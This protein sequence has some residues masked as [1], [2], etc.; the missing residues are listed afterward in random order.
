M[1]IV[2]SID[3]LINRR[4]KIVA[5]VGPA[6]SSPQM[7]EALIEAGV[8]VFRLNMSHG[9][10]AG[11]QA[12]Y[13]HIRSIAERLEKPVA[14]LAD[15]CGPKIRTGKFEDDGIDLLEGDEVKITMGQGLGKAGVIVSQY[16]ALARDVKVNDRILLAD[17]LFELCVLDS[18]E[19]EVKCR[20]VQGGRLTNNKGMNLPGVDVSSPC[21]TPKDIRDAEFAKKLG[22]DFIA[23]SF[24]RTAEDVLRLREL[25]VDSG[26]PPAIVAKIEK[27]EALD[28]AEAIL[29]VTDAIMIARGDLGVELPPEE[30]PIA[31]KQLI[32]MAI[33]RG[34]PVIV[35]TQ[36]LESMITHAR[37]TRAEVTDVSY[38]VTSGADAV[39]L[40]AETAAGDFPIDSVRM[41]DRVARQAE[42]H[43]WSG[44]AWGVELDSSVPV[45]IWTA[46]A[47]AAPKMSKN[48]GA[49][50][51]IV[52]SKSGITVQ[53]VSTARPAAPIL[54]VTGSQRV[55]NKTSLLWGVVPLIDSR[56]GKTNP[57]ELA[58]RL[59]LDLGLASPGQFV[60]LIRGFH[61]DPAMNLPSVT[62]V[63]ITD[64]DLTE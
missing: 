23:L 54:A 46:V 30:V 2:T 34:K 12:A 15:L 53:T 14:I 28:N 52:V 55:F 49:R 45:T 29:E 5:T 27:P 59:A 4:T 62:V 64:E 35:A 41:M 51:V 31:Q 3:L 50:A 40:S 19:T 11:H 9:E 42:A 7:I 57:N 22:V 38:A 37:P 25:L 24:V 6:S 17:G 26:D 47:S 21:L 36:M 32:E 13:D 1:A 18:S 60:L 8:N 43:L 16:E 56:A 58:K 33:A 48:L 61:Q 39:M 63:T 10:P 44:G 20:V